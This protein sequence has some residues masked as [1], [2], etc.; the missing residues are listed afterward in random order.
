VRAVLNWAPKAA[1]SIADTASTSL[2]SLVLS[3]SVAREGGVMQLGLFAMLLSIHVLVRSFVAA[4]VTGPLQVIS[5]FSQEDA[6]SIR[7]SIAAGLAAIYLL[8]SLLLVGLYLLADGPVIGFQPA[9]VALLVLAIGLNN[10]QEFCRS[11]LLGEGQHRQAA[12]ISLVSAAVQLLLC[13]AL[14]VLQRRTG[15]Q[16]VDVSA[17]LGVMSIGGAFG[18]AVGSRRT[19]RLIRLS[20]DRIARDL[21]RVVTFGSWGAASILVSILYNQGLYFILGATEG[22][23][24]VGLFEGPRL[25]VAP[26][27]LLVMSW[28]N[29]VVP[30]ATR[31]FVASGIERAVAILLKSGLFLVAATSVYVATLMLA[32]EEVLRV[33]L[34][35]AFQDARDTLLFWAIASVAMVVG[36]IV[37]S[38][39]QITGNPSQGF[40]SRA[41]AA[42][43]AFGCAFPLI[44]TYGEAGAAMARCVGEVVICIANLLFAWQLARRL[45]RRPVEGDRIEASA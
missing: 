20:R 13:L 40:F 4:G 24:S 18:V 9:H 41:V 28:S 44:A 23:A 38:I 45:S 35:D 8:A 33:V 14:I 34:G 10:W 39:F 32:S 3:M 43:S 6:P 42:V 12:S 2:A 31:A 22:A 19:A 29:A 25:L 17:V 1:W 11:V 21:R 37:S 30:H 16:M 15:D 26:V 27:V 5:I 7:G 36:T